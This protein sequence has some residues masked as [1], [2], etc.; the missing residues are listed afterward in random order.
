MNEWFIDKFIIQHIMCCIEFQCIIV[1]VS[2]A[3]NL[4]NNTS[5]ALILLLII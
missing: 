3:Y 2:N 5:I 4:I 1:Q